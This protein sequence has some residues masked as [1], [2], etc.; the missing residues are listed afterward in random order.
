MV[1]SFNSVTGSCRAFCK[2]LHLGVKIDFFF[3][4]KTNQSKDGGGVQ[5]GPAGSFWDFELTEEENNRINS[6][7]VR[8]VEE[9]RD[10]SK[11]DFLF[12]LSFFIGRPKE[13]WKGLITSQ[14]KGDLR[15]QSS[16]CSGRKIRFQNLR[17]WR[18]QCFSR[19]SL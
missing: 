9:T 12:F 10:L 14:I 8:H 1:N 4:C 11:S 7:I 16:F 2:Q 3:F 18:G 17:G 6:L 5:H 19:L 13:D 15:L